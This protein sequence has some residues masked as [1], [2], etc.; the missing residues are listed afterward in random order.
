MKTRRMTYIWSENCIHQ[1]IGFIAAIDLSLYLR[2]SLQA[3]CTSSIK[4]EALIATIAISGSSRRANCILPEKKSWRRLRFNRVPNGNDVLRL[5][6]WMNEWM[7][8]SSTWKIFLSQSSI[9]SSSAIYQSRWASSSFLSTTI[10]S[11]YIILLYHPT[12]SN[13]N[14]NPLR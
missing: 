7:N 11:K 13:G 5:Y 8:Q 4:V 14:I 9:S 1:S 3:L 6:E 12:K 2:P 10:Y